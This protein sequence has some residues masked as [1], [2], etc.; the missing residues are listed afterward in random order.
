MTKK[1]LVT[2]LVM[3][4][5]MVAVAQNLRVESFRELTT[6]MTARI[7]APLRDQNGEWCALIKVTSNVL[8]DLEFQSPG[9]GI[10]KIEKHTG[11]KWLYIPAG[12]KTISL[13]HTF[14]GALRDY[15]YPV[16]IERQMVYEMS[17]VGNAE[18]SNSN[19]S[20]SN[21]VIK[22][23]GNAEI[24]INGTSR[25]YGTWAGTLTEGNYEVECRLDNCVS[26]KSNIHV[27]AGRD[28]VI[29]M[30]Q[31]TPFAGH[32]HVT[33]TPSSARVILDGK[34]MRVVTPCSLDNILVGSHN[35][36]LSLDN[37][38]TG[39]REV[40]IKRD[41]TTNLNLTFGGDVTIN[42][43]PAGAALKIN[44]KEAGTT[45]YTTYLTLGDYSVTLE[46]ENYKT[47]T[48]TVRVETKPLV[49]SFNLPY[50]NFQS[51]S[52]YANLDCK[53]GSFPKAGVTV[54]GAIGG[55][56]RNF[57]VEVFYQDD[58]DTSYDI[59]WI[60]V[61]W[62]ETM[63]ESYKSKPQIGVRFG[64]GFLMGTRFRVTPRVGVGAQNVEGDKGT[65]CSAVMGSV[66]ARVDIALIKN[67]ALTIAPEYFFAI[68]KSKTYK[69]IS[70]AESVINGWSNGFNFRFGLCFN[71]NL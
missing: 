59:S 62:T 4:C 9:L 41:E 28:E 12:S 20:F 16:K 3:I 21:I 50:K 64:Y 23:E 34:D 13:F 60:D 53:I 15:R 7:E 17:V 66:D 52:V 68:S 39:T 55:Y 32:L 69:L 61:D 45:P 36:E 49:K 30:D 54:G 48:K 33:S 63:S 42:S 35:I 25:G 6:D 40:S 38:N 67:L 44:G 10:A 26:T 1:L 27:T 2:L 8:N 46:K 71:F 14:C 43:K 22:V 31:P 11:E 70:D 18:G 65:K 37:Y 5:C 57:N 47:V 51:N 19:L 58:Y 24:F 56:F 29:N